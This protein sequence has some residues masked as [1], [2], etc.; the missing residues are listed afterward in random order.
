MDLEHRWNGMI[1][2]D[3]KA[4]AWLPVNDKTFSPDSTYLRAWYSRFSLATDIASL[5]ELKRCSPFM[6]R[7]NLAKMSTLRWPACLLATASL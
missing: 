4:T 7:Y 3:P 5:V 2:R 6:T 1:L